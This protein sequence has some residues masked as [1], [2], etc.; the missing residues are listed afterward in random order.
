V[1]FGLHLPPLY[2]FGIP[3]AVFMLAGLVSV[4]MLKKVK[5]SKR[6]HAPESTG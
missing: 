1:I 6:A 3:A 5:H 2:A 4:V